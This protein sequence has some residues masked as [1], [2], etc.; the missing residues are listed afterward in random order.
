MLVELTVQLQQLADMQ[1]QLQ[2]RQ[3]QRGSGGGSAADAPGL[4]PPAS[5]GPRPA[6]GG[7]SSAK[8]QQKPE[9]QPQKQPGAK[10]GGVSCP[11]HCCAS[12]MLGGSLCVCSAM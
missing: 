6:W 9:E 1:Q 2:E 8:P 12:V 10:V 11:L 7:V 3:Q 5:K 4:M